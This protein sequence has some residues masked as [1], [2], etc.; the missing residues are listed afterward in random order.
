MKQKGKL[1]SNTLV[2]LL[3]TLNM[4]RRQVVLDLVCCTLATLLLTSYLWRRME[5]KKNTFLRTTFQKQCTLPL[6]VQLNH[7]PS[8]YISRTAKPC[9]AAA[10][11]AAAAAAVTKTIT[12]VQSEASC[13]APSHIAGH[14]LFAAKDILCGQSIVVALDYIN[15]DI[16][17]RRPIIDAF[18]PRVTPAGHR[19]NHCAVKSN[20]AIL[21]EVVYSAAAALNNT[22][23]YTTTG[24]YILTST[25]F[26][27]KGEELTLDY[28]DLPWYLLQPAP[29]WTC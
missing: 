5:A 2:K 24:R 28:S 15:N 26:I 4:R 21:P 1:L 16:R 8:L 3:E 18:I 22:K 9:P 13:F 20:S 23:Y 10:A 12:M 7:P 17:V 27:T 29:W 19:I 11:A 6:H 25:R 14:G